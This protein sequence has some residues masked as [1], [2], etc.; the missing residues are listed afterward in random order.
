MQIR[1]FADLI[2]DKHHIAQNKIIYIY[3]YII[4][5]I[6]IF[7]FHVNH[8]SDMHRHALSPFSNERL[9][10]FIIKHIFPLNRQ[11]AESNDPQ[12]GPI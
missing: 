8:P 10:R 6:R 9:F 4:K 1:I 11:K 5:K 3:F 2:N 7:K 12:N